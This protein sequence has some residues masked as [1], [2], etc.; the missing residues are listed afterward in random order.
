MI[1]FCIGLLV[2]A[3]SIV[4]CILGLLAQFRERARLRRMAAEIAARE[5]L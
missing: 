2:G 4:G 3:A 1:Y 5:G